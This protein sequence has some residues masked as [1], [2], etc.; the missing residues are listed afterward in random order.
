VAIDKLAEV[1]GAT[2]TR[3]DADTV[4]RLT[5]FSIGGVPPIGH[6][7]RLPTYCDPVLL[8]YTSVWAAAGT[9]NAV[10]AISPAQLVQLAEAQVA[11]F[12]V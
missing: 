1:T 6:E 9:P 5:G 8:G 7:T 10:F 4:R 2:I 11:D 3:P 12:C